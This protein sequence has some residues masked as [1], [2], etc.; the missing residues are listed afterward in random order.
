MADEDFARRVPWKWGARRRWQDQAGNQAPASWS[1]TPRWDEVERASTMGGRN[2]SWGLGELGELEMAGARR[3]SR[4]GAGDARAQGNEQSRTEA[5]LRAGESHGLET[6]R[7][8][9]LPGRAAKE[10]SRERRVAH[11]GAEL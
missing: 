1:W 5:P 2:P 6:R 8:G 10:E 3:P 7:D 4:A 11:Q 9:E